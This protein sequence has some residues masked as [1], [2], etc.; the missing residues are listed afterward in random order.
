MTQHT[1]LSG[2]QQTSSAS[3]IQSIIYKVIWVFSAVLTLCLLAFQGTVWAAQTLLRY[4]SKILFYSIIALF[5]VTGFLILCT[6]Y[7]IS[8]G[9]LHFP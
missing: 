7:V 3:I 8:F 4:S 9:T 2:E 6:L 1:Y 5:F